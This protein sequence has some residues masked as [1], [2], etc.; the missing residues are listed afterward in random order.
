M[1]STPDK[2]NFSRP[3]VHPELRHKSK[4]P[5][6]STCNQRHKHPRGLRTLPQINFAHTFKQL[7]GKDVDSSTLDSPS[8]QHT[9]CSQ[10]FTP[11][12][13]ET[14]LITRCLLSAKTKTT[15]HILLHSTHTHTQRTRKQL[16]TLTNK[17]ANTTPTLDFHTLPSTLS[18]VVFTEHKQA[19]WTLRNKPHL[20]RHCSII[21]QQKS[22]PP[23]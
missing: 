4:G 5:I 23:G 13:S 21:R 15:E 9:T 10:W 22:S 2:N 12:T 1:A 3:Q 14:Q 19:R 7:N 16:S 20:Y 8:T 18:T 17:L 11:F 6:S